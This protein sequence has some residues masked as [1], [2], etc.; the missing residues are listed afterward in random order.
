VRR[1]SAELFA[2]S[3]DEVEDIIEGRQLE[4]TRGL[5][6]P[7]REDGARMRSFERSF[8]R[9]RERSFERSSSLD[10]APRDPAGERL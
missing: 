5:L 1:R 7:R 10:P 9:S 6:P 2:I 3:R 4:R 8:E